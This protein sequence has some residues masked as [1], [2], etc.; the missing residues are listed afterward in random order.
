MFEQA[1]LAEVFGALL[2]KEQQA[3]KLCAD[4]E[5]KAADPAFRQEIGQLRREKQRHVELTQRLLEIVQ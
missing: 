4:L 1:S 5:A 3:A 2:A